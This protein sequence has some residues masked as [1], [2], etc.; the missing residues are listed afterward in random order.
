MTPVREFPDI[1]DSTSYMVPILG[2]GGYCGD[3]A[4]R[5]ELV[6]PYDKIDARKIKLYNTFKFSTAVAYHLSPFAIS[7]AVNALI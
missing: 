5:S 7:V 1:S 3:L 2:F 4:T 6:E